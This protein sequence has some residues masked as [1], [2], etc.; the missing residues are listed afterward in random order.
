MGGGVDPPGQ[1]GGGHQDLDLASHKKALASGSVPI[2]QASMVHA[3]PKLEGMPQVE[4][5]HQ[6]C[7]VKSHLESEVKPNTGF[8]GEG[9]GAAAWRTCSEP[10]AFPVCSLKDFCNEVTYAPY[11]LLCADH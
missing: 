6:R 4:I 10:T 9:A 8:D 7:A 3:N 11:T 5:L 2:S 1:G